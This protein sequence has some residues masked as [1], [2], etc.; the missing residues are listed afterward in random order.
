MSD[1]REEVLK[2]FD[3]RPGRVKFKGIFFLYGNGVENKI[4]GSYINPICYLPQAVI[5]EFE[6]YFDIVAY[7][8]E[9]KLKKWKKGLNFYKGEQHYLSFFKKP[10]KTS[11]QNTFYSSNPNRMIEDLDKYLFNRNDA[12]TMVIFDSWH[13]W[14]Q[15]LFFKDSHLGTSENTKTIGIF[16]RW[17]KENTLPRNNHLLFILT[18]EKP[19]GK[20]EQKQLNSPLDK[21]IQRIFHSCIDIHVTPPDESEIYN[22]LIAA[23]FK[24]SISFRLAS[25]VEAQKIAA[26]LYKSKIFARDGLEI[27]LRLAENEREWDVKNVCE[28]LGIELPPEV[29]PLTEISE[30]QLEKIMKEQVQGQD[31]SISLIA[32]EIRNTLRSRKKRKTPIANFMLVGPP[33]SGKTETAKALAQALSGNSEDFIFFPANQYPGEE[34]AVLKAFGPSPGTPGFKNEMKQDGGGDLTGPLIKYPGK[35]FVILIDEVEKASEKFRQALFTLLSEGWAED[36]SA[37][38]KVFFTNCVIISTSNFADVKIAKYMA[39]KPPFQDALLEVEKIMKD[40][41]MDP[42]FLGRWILIPYVYPQ[43]GVLKQI[44]REKITVRAAIE[45]IKI[46]YIDEEYLDS[47]LEKYKDMT[48]GVR[49][50]LKSVLRDLQG[51]I[52]D[53]QP[54]ISYRINSEGLILP[55]E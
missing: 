54:N 36:F 20:D 34:Q 50:L 10:P 45:K 48:T 44:L 14:N 22:A 42:A 12:K 32:R 18:P 47:V 3:P 26:L 24:E 9:I 52:L 37:Q 1:W 15:M 39:K 55:I 27:I 13:H 4:Y 8:T 6:K 35:N 23:H 40:E 30:S 7:Y 16:R 28:T 21:M 29:K 5:D 51:K 25:E 49:G 31:D 11:K 53:C 19:F 38:R 41:K 46:E 2:S 43:P 17:I 33:G